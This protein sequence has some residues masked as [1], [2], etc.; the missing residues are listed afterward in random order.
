MTTI[1]FQ[2]TNTI[3]VREHEKAAAEK[4]A[5]DNLADELEESKKLDKL[6]SEADKCDLKKVAPSEVEKKTWHTPVEIN[7]LISDLSKSMGVLDHVGLIATILLFNKGAANV[8]TPA[9]MTVLV[10]DQDGRDIEISKD[11]LVHQY[12]KKFK[13]SYI[14]RLAESMSTI[15]GTYSEKHGLAG[16]LSRKINNKLIAENKTQLTRK[17]A[18][19]T[20]S[21]HQNNPILP[22]VSDRMAGLLAAD[23]ADRFKV[24]DQKAKASNT[25]VANSDAK[26]PKKK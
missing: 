21:F 13:N 10:I 17:E 22:Q 4:V 11:E 8:G 18:A 9:T 6:I 1:S 7:D 3:M 16:D 23:Y 24:K 25:K 12:K 15:I 26:K 2:K 14:R 20:S 19:W 5:K